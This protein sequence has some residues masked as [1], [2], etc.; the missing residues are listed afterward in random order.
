M[1]YT[2]EGNPMV[3]YKWA[4]TSVDSPG[5]QQPT[6]V[7]PYMARLHACARLLTCK[8]LDELGEN[9]MPRIS[10]ESDFCIVSVPKNQF[11]SSTKEILLEIMHTVLLAPNVNRYFESNYNMCQ[12][13]FVSL[14]Q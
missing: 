6:D 13:F 2:S 9:T 12:L 14:E 5:Q 10:I 8:S 3:L 7:R 11:G 4:L 1:P